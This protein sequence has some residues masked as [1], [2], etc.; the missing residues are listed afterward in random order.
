MK[1]R[2]ILYYKLLR[3]AS[4]SRMQHRVSFLFL[5]C[6]Q[7]MSGISEIA[8]IWILCHRFSLV[9]GWTLPELSVIYG[10]THMG[11]AIA[12]AFARGFDKFSMLLRNGDF[13]RLL[14]RPHSTLLQVAAHQAEMMKIGRFLQGALVLIWG[15]SQLHLSYHQLIIT[16]LAIM[17]T[18][19]LFYGLFIIQATLSFW[20]TETLEIMHITTYGGRDVGQYP[21]PIYHGM[22][23]IV[24][25][26]IIPLGVV[27][28]YPAATILGRESLPLWIA[29]IAPSFGGIFLLAAC[30][31][32]NIG[33]RRYHSTGS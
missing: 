29:V 25:T 32:W 22:L 24:F 8:G 10:I 13:D 12:E 2:I 21:L 20:T 4:R 27:L 23:K 17:G 14:L 28:Y 33:V 6:A 9:Q 31:F 1:Q 11:F 3:A 26:A 15:Y 30:G 7:F 5:T 18:A 16:T 19:C